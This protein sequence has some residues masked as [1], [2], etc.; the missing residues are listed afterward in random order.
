MCRAPQ[1]LRNRTLVPRESED[2]I[3]CPT[4]WLSSRFP[5][6]R[7]M[8]INLLPDFFAVLDSSDRNA[9]YLRYF[10]A[11]RPILEA[12]WQ[13]YVLDPDGP[14]F[15][16][17]VRQTMAA[18]RDD[19]RTTLD[20]ADIAALARAATDATLGA[21]EAERPTPASSSF[22]DAGPHS[23]A[24]STSPA[25]PTPTRKASASSPS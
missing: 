20:R 12:Y 11:H 13:N 10:D 17:V 9:A 23:F 19:L 14:H 6:L 5:A 4:D 18:P 21:L 25:P 1:P 15:F 16:D 24:S 8:L 3:A 22:V 7:L 2:Y